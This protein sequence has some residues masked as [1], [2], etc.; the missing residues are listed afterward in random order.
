MI[1]IPMKILNL[2][3]LI[4]P[5]WYPLSVPPALARARCGGG[6]RR[7]AGAS[8]PLG[9]REQRDLDRLRMNRLI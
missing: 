4:L 6:Q 3:N 8:P 9:G 5:E 2:L 1:M 7:A